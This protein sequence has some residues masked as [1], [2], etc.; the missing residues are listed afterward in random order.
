MEQFNIKPDGFKEIRKMILI[1][2][3]PLLL[4]AIFGG[5]TISHFTVKERYNDVDAFPMVIP[6]I[7]GA[8]AYGLYRAMNRQ[9]KSSTAID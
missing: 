3:I 1:K 6:I 2:I 9:K 7:L 5:I 4:L 8:S